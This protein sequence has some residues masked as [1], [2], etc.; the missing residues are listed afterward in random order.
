MGFVLSGH[1]HI[2]IE[3]WYS[4]YMKGLY[5]SSQKTMHSLKKTNHCVEEF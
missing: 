1:P 2:V 3:H 5:E 4:Q